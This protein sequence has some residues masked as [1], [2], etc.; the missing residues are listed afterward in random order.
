MTAAVHLS[1]ANQAERGNYDDKIID[2]V[3]V[4]MAVQGIRKIRLTPRERA[5]AVRQ[6]VARGA[7]PG[8]CPTAYTSPRPWS[9]GSLTS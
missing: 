7:G 3:A 4:A 1:S 6:L 8:R 5:E 2:P 9:W